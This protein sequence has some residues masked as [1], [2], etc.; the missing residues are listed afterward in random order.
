MWAYHS[1]GEQIR[2]TLVSR[3]QA[4]G[5]AR[6][7]GSRSEASRFGTGCGAAAKAVAGSRRRLA[8]LRAIE[9]REP[10][11]KPRVAAAK[12]RTADVP[13]ATKRPAARQSSPSRSQK[14]K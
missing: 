1:I 14:R 8:R 11:P 4:A 10:P 3:T 9:R 2:F 7:D 6:R 12:K 13:A 5:A